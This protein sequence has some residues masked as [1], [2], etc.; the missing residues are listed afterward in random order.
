MSLTAPAGQVT[1]PP[2]P[3]RMGSEVQPTEA[4]AYLE[5]LGRWRDERRT[6]LDQLDEA[7]LQAPE[8]IGRDQR[9][10]LVHGLVEGGVGPLRAAAD[11]LGLGPG[12]TRP[13][14]RGWPR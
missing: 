5:Q 8:R 11:H 12:G 1:A 7:A 3:G 14:G 2:A 10:H 4:M 13:S 9:H 6:E